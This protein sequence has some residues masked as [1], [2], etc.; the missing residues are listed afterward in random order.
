MTGYPN[1]VKVAAI[2]IWNAPVHFQHTKLQHAVLRKEACRNS[3]DSYINVS[4]EALQSGPRPRDSFETTGGG[5]FRPVGFT[6]VHKR[7]V[8]HNIHLSFARLGQK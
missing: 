6:Q 5:T 7:V 8:N 4:V 2:V 3:E 1:Y